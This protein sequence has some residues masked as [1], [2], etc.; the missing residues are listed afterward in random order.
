MNILTPAQRGFLSNFFS[1]THARAFYLTGGGALG[2]Y[3]LQHRLSLDIDLF[4]QDRK[5]WETIGLELKTAAQLSGAELDFWPLKPPNELLRVTLKLPDEKGITI[6]LVRDAPPHFGDPVMRSDGVIVDTLE[7]IAVGKLL[8]TYGRAYSRDF[9]DLYF[10]LQ[11]GLDFGHLLD[12]GREKDLGLLDL[13]LAEM[14]LN[15]SGI[16]T[17]DMPTML[18][19]IDLDQLKQL[20]LTLA[21]NLAKGQYS[22]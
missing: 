13:P 4:T 18:K 3:Y 22:K 7:N 15:V 8:A 6:D 20:F 21:D 12:L 10:L 19:P 16:E 17:E 9:V 11:S 5:A 1:Q 2:E 14:F